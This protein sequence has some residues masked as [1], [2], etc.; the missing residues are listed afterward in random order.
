MASFMARRTVSSV[1]RFPNTVGSPTV[2]KTNKPKKNPKKTHVAICQPTVWDSKDCATIRWQTW[3][4]DENKS[5]YLW[6]GR[7]W[8]CLGLAWASCC[9]RWPW[10]G[11]A[12]CWPS[13]RAS[14]PT[15]AC[16]FC[17]WQG[18]NSHL[19]Q[20]DECH[21]QWLLSCLGF[22]LLMGFFHELHLRSSEPSK[23]C[24]PS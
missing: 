15:P 16:G 8:A 18:T 21:S 12:C 10:W 14:R 2:K 7:S 23:P 13:Q 24:C 6:R 17:P 4:E 9:P 22:C 20:H 1:G 3:K 11:W 19:H 5:S